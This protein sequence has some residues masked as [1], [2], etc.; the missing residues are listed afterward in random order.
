MSKKNNAN[1]EVPNERLDLRCAKAIRQ[2][3]RSVEMYSQ[4]LASDHSVTVPQLT[5][6]TKL[7]DLGP[8]MLKSLAAEIYLSPSTCVGIVDR[9]ENKGLVRRERSTQDRRQVFLYLT[10][11]GKSAVANSP[12]PLHDALGT[13]LD[14]LDGLE[15]MTIVLSLETVVELL[16]AEKVDASPILDSGAQ[17]L[18]KA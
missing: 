8:M 16:S 1:H 11:R 13:A 15:Q 6:L 4:G 9:L 18:E 10:E 12:S 14:K 2:I 7:N 3:I 17:L 5:A